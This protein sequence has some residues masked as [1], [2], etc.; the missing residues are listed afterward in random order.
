MQDIIGK[1][2]S[3]LDTPCLVIDKKLLVS[4]IEAMQFEVNAAHKNLRPHAKTHKCTQICQQQIDAGAIGICVT[5]VS[6]AVVL[7]EKRFK[8][9][10]ITSP[11]VTPIKIEKLLQCLIE[12]SQLTVAIDNLENATVLNSS[13][14]NSN[15]IINVLIDIDPGIGRTGISYDNVLEFA[16]TLTQFSHLKLTGIQ[17]YAGNLQHI[18]DYQ[19]R[20]KT[21]F[22]T[23][24]KAAICVKQLK[25]AGFNCDILTGSGTGTYDIDMQILEVTEIQPGSYTV[26]DAEYYAIGSKE[27]AH[28]NKKYQPALT[29][30][31]TVISVNQQ[32][33]VTCD[34]G[35]KALYEVPTKPIILK[36]NGYKYD[37]GGFGDE[38]GKITAINNTKLPQLG[39]RLELMVAH[40]DPTINMYDYFYITE[41][42]IVVDVWPIDMRGRSQ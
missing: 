32:S 9:T 14:K 31:T 1:S 30:L 41:N 33:H 40:C 17:C 22:E 19:T 15:L 12:D 21:S 8:N 27:N 16:R 10:L 37:W 29:L 24:K 11:V 4:N 5:K 36:P 42:D 2:K 39:D 7:A 28:Q 3:L 6:E 23:M 26:M 20:Y 34:A 38:H 13:A 25:E 18:Q 35:W